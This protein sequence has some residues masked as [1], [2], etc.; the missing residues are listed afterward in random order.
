[1]CMCLCDANVEVKLVDF[2][3]ENHSIRNSA[4]TAHAN[5]ISTNVYFQ[6]TTRTNNK[7][8]DCDEA[9]DNESALIRTNWYRKWTKSH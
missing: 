2:S 5:F 9:N 6:D 3:I 1:M 4:E 8:I 7:L